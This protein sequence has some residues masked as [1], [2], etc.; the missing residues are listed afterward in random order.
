MPECIICKERHH[1]FRMGAKQPYK[2]YDCQQKYDLGHKDEIEREQQQ[3]DEDFQA[4]YALCH[5]IPMPKEK[6]K[7]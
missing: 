7:C 2:C 1:V 5:H 6:P 4:N 3:E